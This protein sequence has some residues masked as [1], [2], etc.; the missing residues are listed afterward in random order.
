VAI[1][2]A[3]GMAY[4]VAILSPFGDDGFGASFVFLGGN[5]EI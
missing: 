3:V 1:N 5:A 2:V 4:S